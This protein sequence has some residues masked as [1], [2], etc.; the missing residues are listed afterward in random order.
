MGTPGD[1]LAA[2]VVG[3][4]DTKGE[5][6][7]FIAA[8]IRDQGVA[9]VTVDV[10]TS[11]AAPRGCDVSNAEVAAAHPG[12]VRGGLQRRARQRGRGDG[13]GARRLSAR[14]CGRGRRRDRRRRL[15]GRRAALAG[16][17]GVAGGLPQAA[18]VHARVGRRAR[19][20]RQ[21]RHHDAVPGRRRVGAEPHL[22]PGAGQRRARDRRHG[23]GLAARAGRRAAG[24]RAD[25][26]RRH[27]ALR[28]GRHRAARGRATTASSSTPPAPAG[29]RWRSSSRRAC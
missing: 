10:S 29:S 15:R 20:R 2:Y 22:A 8:R 13:A 18:G 16:A 17:A 24:D 14:A 21:R 26:V 4:F 6:L 9:V 5:E 7:D 27:H 11:D 3:S 28:A 12:G 1:P 23:A 19:L 25:D